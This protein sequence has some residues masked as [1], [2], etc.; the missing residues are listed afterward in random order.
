MG[1]EKD[2]KLLKIAADLRSC[3][4]KQLK[5]KKTAPDT[6]QK[7]DETLRLLHEL[8]VHQIE[9]EM[10]N[11][12]LRQARDK[13]EVELGKFA[14]LYDFAP[15]AYATLD[16]EGVVHAANIAAA[17]M[18][19]IDLS[20]LLGRRF[21]VFIADE[22]LLCF[23][24]FL[25]KVYTSFVKECCEVN[26]SN[27]GNARHFVQIEAVADKSDQQVRIGIVDITPHK[28]LELSLLEED[29][30]LKTIIQTAMDGFY[31]VDTQGRLLEV[32]ESYC[33]MSGY[34]RQE[35]Q[36]MNITDLEAIET[37]A[38]TC[39]HIRKIS[40]E[41]TD[42]FESKHRRKDG[43]VYDI[44]ASVQFQAIADGQFVVFLRDI[45][46]RKQFEL[47][48]QKA[49][50][51][52]ESAVLKRTADI[53]RSNEQLA[54]EI[55]ERKKAEESLHVA[56]AE[57]ERLKELL[58]AEN[59]YLQR[60]VGKQFN[61]G[62]II[63]QSKN[64]ATVFIRIQQVAPMNAT[65]LLLGETGTGKGVVARAI[66]SRSAR[67]NRAMI[68]VNCTA[69]PANLIESELFGRERGAFTGASERQIGRFELADGGTIF[70]DEIGEMPMDLQCKLLRVIQDGEFERLGSPR[71]IKVDVRIIAATNR[72]LEEEIK[73][74]RFREDLFYRLN[75]F[76]ITIPPLR[77]RTDDIP[78][79]V[80]HFVA[81]FNRKNSKR[82]ETVTKETLNALQAYHWPGNVRELE[83]IVE[84]AVIISQGTTLQ[85]L[86]FFETNFKP[87]EVA[88]QSVKPLVEM[89]H[90]HI[91]QALQSTNWRID[92]KKGAALILGLNPST[93]RA[94]MRKYGI[95][96]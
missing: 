47:E 94:R 95:V 35:L 64:L 29:R 38:D 5:S 6:P 82:I 83:S 79:L 59:I 23:T 22:D 84:R 34:S 20:R 13:M 39:T 19:G 63:G 69:L 28:Q 8:Q 3:A 41:G 18:L 24:E 62:E 33:Q 32:N 73:N 66:H 90:D 53:S 15:V 45:S 10:Q 96:R 71:T 87:V 16:R 56:Y 77:Q 61:F 12:E 85:V 68:T 14:D 43:T 36:N 51:S 2:E 60:E 57:V 78:L 76:P 37:T 25:E 21:G 86:D 40:A 75:V 81:K 4:E 54:H 80:N 11:V 44:E 88:G 49:Y 70:L 89:E 27:R 55:D 50:E 17:D 92:G 67:K 48:R 91:M 46:A 58:Q 30:K 74:G 93:L 65:V 52:L 72:N 31:V 9:L 26:I 42:R 7:D 1:I